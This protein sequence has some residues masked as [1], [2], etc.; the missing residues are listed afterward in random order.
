MPTRLGQI[1]EMLWSAENKKRQGLGSNAIPTNT[2]GFYG[3][4]REG[5]SARQP[6]P[7]ET[8]AFTERKRIRGLM[9]LYGKGGIM[10][11]Q[12]GA[13]AMKKAIEE[14]T[15]Q[16]KATGEREDKQLDRESRE[17]VAK[18]RLPGDDGK[19]GASPTVVQ[20]PTSGPAVTMPGAITSGPSGPT[21]RGT[22]PTQMPGGYTP[23]P[24][25]KGTDEQFLD[26]SG[27]PVPGTK[28]R[29]LPSGTGYIT[30]PEG[31]AGKDNMLGG[32]TGKAGTYALNRQGQSKYTPLE[33]SG[34]AIPLPQDMNDPRGKSAGSAGVSKLSGPT[35]TTPTTAIPGVITTPDG[36]VSTTTTPDSITSPPAFRK[37]NAASPGGFPQGAP[38]GEY[39]RNQYPPIPTGVPSLSPAAAT[40]PGG[41]NQRS[42]LGGYGPGGSDYAGKMDQG[43]NTMADIGAWLQDLFRKYNER[44]AKTV[45]EKNPRGKKKRPVYEDPKGPFTGRSTSMKYPRE[46]D[47][48]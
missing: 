46:I 35:T 15:K 28:F 39:G 36:Q 13:D 25:I 20:M 42:L 17:R 18:W 37:I 21:A 43:G 8:N 48:W 6:T 33:T 47:N 41:F 1:D 30:V 10:R 27:F 34:A 45:P 14:L 38:L 11:E 22:I 9:G 26:K 5:V 40:M 23:T 7:E 29:D 32:K 12:M 44:S 4:P 31:S 2:P 16:G 3:N 24:R 19:P